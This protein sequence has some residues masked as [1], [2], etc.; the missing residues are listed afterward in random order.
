M[1]LKL[2][3]TASETQTIRTLTF[4][5][6][7]GAALPGYTAGAHV[8][9]EL[10]D[11]GTRSYSLVDWS[12]D[13]FHP[14]AYVFGIQREADGQ[15]GSQAMHALSVGQEMQA[16]PPK[17]DFPLGS[18]HP[19]VLIAGGIGLTP[20]ITMAAQLRREERDFTLHYAARTQSLAAFLDP[21]RAAF[22]D[23]FVA[24]FDDT[25]MIDPAAVIANRPAGAH[26]YV[27]GPKGMIE[28]VKSIGA[29]AGMPPEEI[30]FELFTTP[31]AR[32]D[33]KP[34]E[35]Q[36][37]SGDI[38]TVPPG[39][40]IIEVLSGEGVDLTFDCQ[41]GDCGICRTEVLEGTPDHRDVVLSDAE[42]AVGNVMQI[43]VSRSKSTRLVLDID[44]PAQ[45]K[46]PPRPVQISAP[47]TQTPTVQPEEAS[48]G[49]YTG[50]P[51]AVRAL[52]TCGQ[53]HRD[54]YI[55]REIYDLEMKHL[56][57]NTWVYVGHDSQVQHKGDYF[58]TQIGNQPVIMVRHTDGQVCVLYN[59]CPHKG[60][61]IAIDRE[62]NTGKFF[63]C[64]YHAWSF[65]TDGCLLAI[66]L[67]KGYDGTTLES[68]P[69]AQGMT[70]VGAVKNYRG[71]IFARLAPEGMEFEEFFGGS[72]SSLDN[73]VD[74]SP[75]GRLEVA[76]P[77]LRYINN[78]NWKM[79]VENQTDTCHPMV[80]HESSAGTAVR[81]YEEMGNPEPRPPA[82]EIIA[83]FMSPYEFMEGMGI[84][85]WPN[86]HGHTG[87]NMSIHSDYSAIP[88]YFDAMTK[89][90]GE[91]GAKA[92][93][94][95]N[96]HN[97]VYFPS[98]MIKGP[99]QQ[100][101]N[102]I[103]LGP[104]KTLIESWIYRLVGAPDQLLA[105]TAMYNRMINA[106][107][108]MV[109]HD[110]TEMYE[111]AQEGLTTQGLEWVDLNR[112]YTGPESFEGE[113][114][115]NGTTERQMRNQFHAWVKFMTMSMEP[116][117]EAAE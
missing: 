107:T 79:L 98:I 57:A 101:R 93:L 25:A 88:G 55:D 117:M 61:K 43:C 23:R 65:K 28:A 21:M 81:L 40:T 49:R 48:M 17:N 39:K 50:N 9:F 35:V 15:G 108:S 10:G 69:N 60:T 105:R 92:I 11:L 30:H 54:V 111:R 113:L 90:Y 36:I 24:H 16:T 29:E 95:E 74:R 51:Q 27:C 68:T 86:G 96:R 91:D 6:A 73:M 75:E 3:D 33:D 80:A 109:G 1:K 53:V 41:R 70:P 58:T 114:I 72:L 20:M 89:A 62:G 112:L 38:Y 82:M 63:R 13:A 26:V 104:D 45:R 12:G 18:D 44:G 64:P 7:D 102:F 110:D 59:R 56:W 42:R 31:V 34:F 14:D 67:R 77:P 47:K 2:A 94:D 97:T 83:P 8:T 22:G 78:C 103:P 52:F 19:A 71:F 4:V 85:T 46:V 99:I 5:A 100:L 76:G 115:E 116:Q 87:V 66:P 37:N 84:R 106:S 32:A